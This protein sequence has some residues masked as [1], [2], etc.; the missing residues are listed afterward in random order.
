V[1]KAVFDRERLDLSEMFRL[2]GDPRRLDVLLICRQKPRSVTEVASAAGC[3]MALASHHLRLLRMGN[4]VEAERV[5]R[6]AYYRLAD[7]H[8]SRMLDQMLHHARHCRAPMSSRRSQR[9]V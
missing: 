7:T 2:L 9:T 3:S 4:L 6:Q 1:A 8:V 5:G